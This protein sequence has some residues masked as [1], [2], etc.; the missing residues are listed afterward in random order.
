M[1]EE[2]LRQFV[3]DWCSGRIFSS[4]HIPEGREKDVRLVFMVLALMD[5]KKA[6]IDSLGII[7]EYMSAALSRTINGMPTFMSCRLMHK[8]DWARAKQA[9]LREE[10][11]QKELQV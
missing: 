10:E 9:I 6:E 2:Q 4:C 3:I 11:R 7:Y 5:L 8:D 1:P